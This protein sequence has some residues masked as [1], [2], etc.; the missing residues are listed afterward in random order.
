MTEKNDLV[1]HI[2]FQFNGNYSILDSPKPQIIC[3]QSVQSVNL[4][5][6]TRI[7]QTDRKCHEKLPCSHSHL[8]IINF[9]HICAKEFYQ[10]IC[11]QFISFSENQFEHHAW[12]FGLDFDGVFTME[13]HKANL[14]GYCNVICVC[15]SYGD[16]PRCE[17]LLLDAFCCGE[18]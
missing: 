16:Q 18:Q 2:I 7:E 5:F 12:I 15:T 6:L 11:F 9:W 1:T 4:I 14:V 10:R 3:T 13:R 8:Y 17:T